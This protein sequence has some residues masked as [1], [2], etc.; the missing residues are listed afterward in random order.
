MYCA[1][2]LVAIKVLMRTS[3]DIHH[4]WGILSGSKTKSYYCTCEAER[5]FSPTV[6]Y[7][8]HRHKAASVIKR[9]LFS[10]QEWGN[11]S[12]YLSKTL[13]LSWLD[14]VEAIPCEGS[15]LN[16]LN[17]TWKLV[18]S[19]GLN[20]AVSACIW[21]CLVNHSLHTYLGAYIHIDAYFRF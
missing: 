9:L 14:Q 12:L 8:A 1:I 7:S 20:C 21:D 4:P 17:Q 3:E 5:Y 10:P 16:R 13:T 18:S 11:E 2:W 15:K 6:Q 19:W